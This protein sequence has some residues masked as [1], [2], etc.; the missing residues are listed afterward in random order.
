MPPMKGVLKMHLPVSRLHSLRS[1]PYD[2]ITLLWFDSV[3]HSRYNSDC[4]VILLLEWLLDGTAGPSAGRVQSE[5]FYPPGKNGN[6]HSQYEKWDKR[7]KKKTI[8][9]QFPCNQFHQSHFWI[10]VKKIQVRISKRIARLDSFQNYFISQNM[11][12]QVMGKGIIV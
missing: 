1:W 6:L 4:V 3:T 11:N 8:G 5:P 10:V 2:N 12:W 9:I 7:Y